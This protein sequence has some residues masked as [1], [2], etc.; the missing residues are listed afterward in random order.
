[1][2]TAAATPLPQAAALSR[3]RL[4]LARTRRSVWDA[5]QL[6]AWAR[7]QSHLLHFADGCEPLQPELAKE[8]RAAARSGPQ[9]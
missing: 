5:M 9:L 1:M 3:L 8:L 4:W 7:A 2:N 6:A